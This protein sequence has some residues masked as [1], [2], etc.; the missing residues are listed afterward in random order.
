MSLKVDR[1]EP[2]EIKKTPVELKVINKTAILIKDHKDDNIVSYIQ[3]FN[4]SK[5]NKE[6]AELLIQT[7]EEYIET[8]D[9]NAGD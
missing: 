4:N 7:I 5:Q 2:I 1:F 3:L 6:L 9:T 8:G